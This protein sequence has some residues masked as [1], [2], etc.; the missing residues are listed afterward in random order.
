MTD[1]TQDLKDLLSRIDNTP[2]GPEE[3][4]LSAEAVALAVEL[5]NEE[6]E[7][8]ARMRQTASANM[9][10]LTD[11]M[12]NSFAWCLAKYDED[13]SRFP[14]DIEN[15]AADLMWQFKWMAGALRGSPAFEGAQIGAVLDDMEEHYRRAG[16][17]MSGVL[18]ARFEDAWSA[19]HMD[20]AEELRQQLEMT[21]RDSHSHCDACGRSQQA[22]FFAETERDENA[23]RLVEEM[24]EG[25]FSCG[26]E[27][28]HA[29]AR[30]LLPYLRLDRADD[31]KAAH[32]RSYRFARDNADNLSIIAMN[33]TF[34]AVTGN[35]ARAL[36]L[37][38]RHLPWLAH[39]GLNGSAHF[40]ALVAFAH[41]LDAVT[42][43]GHGDAIVR[44]AD[45]RDLAE[46][47]GEHDGAWTAADLAEACWRSAEALGAEFDARNGTRAYAERVAEMRALKDF[48]VEVPFN[49][50]AFVPQLA[51]TVP[52]DPAAWIARAIN[53][54]EYGSEADFL[55]ALPHALEAAEGKERLRLLAAH[56]G[57]LS[58]LDRWEEAQQLLPERI[59]ALRDAGKDAQAQLEE[60]LGLGLFG[61]AEPEDVQALEEA[62]DRAAEYPAE[63][64]ADVLLT[65]G[66]TR[67]REGRLDEAL[68]LADDAIRLFDEAGDADRSANAR[69]AYIAIL[70]AS[71]SADAAMDEVELILQDPATNDGRRA[72]ALE[73]RAR[74]LGGQERYDEG[75]AAA[76][77]TNRILTLLGA[78][79]AL[80]SVAVLAGAL[81]EDAGQPEQAFPRYRLAISQITR[82]NAEV[83]TTALRYRLG[84]ALLASG[85]ADEATEVLADV[86][87]DESRAEVSADSRAATV[88]LLAEAFEAAEQYGNAI[89]AWEAAGDLY[90]EAEM[91]PGV[92]ATLRSRA[93]IFGRFGERDDAIE[94]LEQAEEIVRRHPDEVGLLSD[95]LHILG[96]A[97]G[98]GGDP[99]AFGLFDEVEQIAR[100][101]EATWLLA[102]V[103]DSRARAC[104]QQG[105]TDEAVSIALSAADAFAEG[106]DEASAG[107]S[108]LFAARLLNG[109][110]RQDD[111][112]TI[113]RSVLERAADTPTLRNVAALEAGDILQALGRSAEAAE[114]RSLIEE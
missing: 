16:L 84:R 71:N 24:V 53:L 101:H 68:A 19:G 93:N 86:F 65:L 34:C 88:S 21:P 44:G 46:F 98:S 41:A 40:A 106:G 43:A 56:I 45:D 114:V 37:I 42:R 108:E 112:V 67:L 6:L 102:D 8:Q 4:A 14:A 109:D 33:I 51:S 9:A 73:I 23:V 32:L 11:V 38:E 79:H 74:V 7:Y 52:E 17:G 66:L 20:R 55:E 110:G 1:R 30:A 22:G 39:D 104:A 69:I 105:R 35:E 15:G 77:E 3:R 61:R 36:V 83:D 63:T 13:P 72:R 82:E 81:F 2:W 62:R 49:T 75:A 64:A 25:G 87:E 5:G 113:Y 89:G 103:M 92:V 85:F 76:D 91:E 48:R 31:A 54:A 57:C 59:A 99:R 27:P 111:A 12:L 95:I 100:Q 90:E 50:D 97:Y 10:G 80:P 60:S 70:L 18:T 94:M 96:Q 78:A 58:N 29:L 47:F 26:E 107:G 28:E